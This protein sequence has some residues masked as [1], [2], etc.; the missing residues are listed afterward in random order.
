MVRQ[1][2]DVVVVVVVIIIIIV[3][4]PYLLKTRI[5]R[6]DSGTSPSYCNG[7]V[8][9]KGNMTPSN[10]TKLENLAKGSGSLGSTSRYSS[11]VQ[12]RRRLAEEMR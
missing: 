1:S 6:G 11:L 8:G 5:A 9:S 4:I 7:Q 2:K 12:C 10:N 3:H